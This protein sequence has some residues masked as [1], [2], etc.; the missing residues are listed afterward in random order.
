M[1]VLALGDGRHRVHERDRRAVVGEAEVLRERVAV[2]DQPGS[3]GE[4]RGQLGLGEPRAL[5]RQARA[6][7]A[8]VAADPVMARTCRTRD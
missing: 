7:S 5:A 3:A 4:V 8:A 6:A 2:R 1:V